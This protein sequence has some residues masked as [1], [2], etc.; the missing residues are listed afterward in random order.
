MKTEPTIS[1]VDW[2]KNRI[3]ATWPILPIITDIYWHERLEY[4]SLVIFMEYGSGR[5]YGNLL[6]QSLPPQIINIQ[7]HQN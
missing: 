3:A 2:V 4:Q 1:E 7:K 6:W 5:H